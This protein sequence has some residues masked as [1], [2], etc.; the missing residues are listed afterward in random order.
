MRKLSKTVVAVATMLSVLVM[1]PAS[2]AAPGDIVGEVHGNVNL[3][4]GT[5]IPT[6][7]AA[8]A[9]ATTYNFTG[10]EIV[11]TLKDPFGNAV[12]GTIST[13]G[14]N[15]AGT[16]TSA[17][18]IGTVNAPKC[19]LPATCDPRASFQN[20]N[21]LGTVTGKFWGC[22]AREGT[23]V[24]VKL[25]IENVS[26]NGGTQFS[27]IVRVRAQ[28]TPTTPTPSA[29]GLTAATFSGSFSEDTLADPPGLSC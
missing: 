12:V 18:G 25:H 16:E 5:Y 17:G 20:T 11:G 7:P 10:V 26:V 1:V 15:G 6:D 14:V 9:R 24:F 22:Y 2:H 21:G 13:T 19:T 23:L 3:T 8:A 27:R 29:N 28:F 4:G